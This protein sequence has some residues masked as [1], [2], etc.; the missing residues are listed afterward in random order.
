MASYI[1]VYSFKS[2]SLHQGSLILVQGRMD[3]HVVQIRRE[4]K[5]QCAHH[6]ILK[7]GDEIVILG[8]KS[9]DC[10]CHG[11]QHRPSVLEL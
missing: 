10:I 9:A 7:R 5:V 3:K 11:I 4:Q 6:L 2:I 1:C 8:M